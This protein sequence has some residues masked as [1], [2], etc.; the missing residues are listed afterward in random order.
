MTTHDEKLDELAQESQLPQESVRHPHA[1][2]QQTPHQQPTRHLS[3]T[4]LKRKL[5]L[6]DTDPH[7]AA[8]HET[9][10]SENRIWDGK[11][12]SVDRLKVAI[13]TGEESIRDVVRHTGAVA[14]VGLTDEGYICLVRQYR[15]A[16]DRVTVEIPAGKLEPGEDP[17]A[18]ARRELLEETGMEAAHI[19]YLTTITSS[20]GFSDE[21]VHIYMATGLH[22]V[23]S[24]PDPEEFINVDLVELSDLVDAVLDGQIEDAKTV[25]GALI[26]D[27]VGHRLA[28]QET[29]DEDADAPAVA[30]TPRAATASQEV[31]DVEEH[32]R[33]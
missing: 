7:D 18:A 22:F 2:Y 29:I 8:L 10:L 14:V 4:P 28:L 27:A 26:C 6:G 12:F 30:D 5:V 23:A 25:V 20:V 17:L 21:L 13:P 15:V 32:G 9:V 11:I 24:H 3:G 31:I 19:A 33:S 16:L 1:S